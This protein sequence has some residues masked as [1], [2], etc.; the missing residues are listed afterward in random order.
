M[1]ELFFSSSES[2]GMC[3]APTIVILYPEVLMKHL[4]VQNIFDQHAGNLF[5][6]QILANG[7]RIDF[8]MV[9]TQAAFGLATAPYQ[10][11]LIELIVK[12][13]LV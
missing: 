8:R 7:Y 10:A 5:I 6:I 11:R 3:V 2:G 1:L 13:F 9:I 4:V 12:V